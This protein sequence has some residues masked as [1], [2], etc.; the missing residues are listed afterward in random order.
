LRERVGVRGNSE[1]KKREPP[2][3]F[4]APLQRRGINVYNC[5]PLRGAVQRTEGFVFKTNTTPPFPT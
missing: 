5:S 3:H 4:M 2:R 1:S